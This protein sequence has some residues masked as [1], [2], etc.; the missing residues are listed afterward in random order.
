MKNKNLSNRRRTFIK[1]TS[2]ALL[3]STLPVSLDKLSFSKPKSKSAKQ[4]EVHIF[5]KHLQFL[6]YQNMASFVA[7]IGFDGI[8]LT[9][10]P[11]GHVLPENVERDLPLAVKAIQDSGLKHKLMTT[12]ILDAQDEL[13]QNMLRTASQLG[14]KHYRTGWLSYSQEKPIPKQIE[15]YKKQFATLEQLNRQLGIKGSYQNH[16][17]K[18]VGAPIWDTYELLKNSTTDHLGMQ[19]DI[20]HAVAEAGGSWELGLHLIKDLIN[21]IV[22]KDFKWGQKNGE[23]K[24]IN[25]PLGEG[26][27]DFKRYFSLLKSYQINVPVSLHLEYD[28][29]GAEHG[30]TKLSIDHKEVF[31]RMKTDLTY[32]RKTWLEA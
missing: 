3:A 20:R 16:F 6:N 27:V 10:R 9:V 14:I 17:G 31:K 18:H 29:G 26:M 28:L 5:S 21:T 8:D 22:I 11:K 4:L 13:Q 12:N 19:Y 24:P 15:V 7:E 25:T 1:K 30:D 23:W 2:T 32:L